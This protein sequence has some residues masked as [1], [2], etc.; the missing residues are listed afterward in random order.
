MVF[1]DKPCK[2]QL[3]YSLDVN[4]VADEFINCIKILSEHPAV[5]FWAESIFSLPFIFLVWIMTEVDH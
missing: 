5:W 4:L 1:A 3:F 2:Q